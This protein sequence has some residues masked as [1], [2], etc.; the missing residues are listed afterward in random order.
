MMKKKRERLQRRVRNELFSIAEEEVKKRSLK[1]T[2]KMSLK[3]TSV[4]KMM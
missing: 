2:K 1:Q 4:K 3:Q